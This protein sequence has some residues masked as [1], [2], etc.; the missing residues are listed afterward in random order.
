[1]IVWESTFREKANAF[2]TDFEISILIN[3]TPIYFSELVS[4]N[5]RARA[6]RF[7]VAGSGKVSVIATVSCGRGEDCE[8]FAVQNPTHH[9]DCWFCHTSRLL[10][11][12]DRV[13]DLGKGQIDEARRNLSSLRANNA[14]FLEEELSVAIIALR[15]S[16]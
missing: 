2:I 6:M 10:F 16:S 1:M 12:H 14:I 9:P 7:T 11:L 13:I 15:A 3:I 5:H 4:V 8:S